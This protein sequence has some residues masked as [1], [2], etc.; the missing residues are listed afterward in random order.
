ME[1]TTVREILA[2]LGEILATVSGRPKARLH[3][4]GWLHSEGSVQPPLYPDVCLKIALN[5]SQFPTS[6]PLEDTPGHRNFGVAIKPDLK[7]FLDARFFGYARLHCQK[8]R[9]PELSSSEILANDSSLWAQNTPSRRTR[10][11]T[12]PGQ[13]LEK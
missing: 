12:G 1:A 8:L 4:D 5:F 11:H 10:R 6:L 9:H 13:V 7:S 3:I 2:E